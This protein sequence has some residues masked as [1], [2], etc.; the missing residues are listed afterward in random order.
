VAPGLPAG[1]A[2]PTLAREQSFAIDDRGELVL[3]VIDR[4]VLWR[5]DGRV[6]AAEVIDFKFDGMGSATD[7]P[8]ILAEKT[9]FYSPQLRAYRDAV[10][11]IHRLAPGRVSC[12]LVFMRSGTVVP[13]SD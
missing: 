12:T 7:H 6:V 1:P 13:V 3:G 5:R 4:L 9:A 11:A 8:R 2:E 10:G